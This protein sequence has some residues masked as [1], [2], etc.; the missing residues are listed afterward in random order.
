MCT[1]VVQ[2]KKKVPDVHIYVQNV[3][4]ICYSSMLDIND[5]FADT[6][7]LQTDCN[8]HCRHESWL[9]RCCKMVDHQSDQ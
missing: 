6:V 1:D 4:T 3:T 9:T 5:R 2:L 7:A 8:F